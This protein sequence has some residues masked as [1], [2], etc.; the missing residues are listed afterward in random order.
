VDKRN[1][2]ESEWLEELRRTECPAEYKAF[3]ECTIASA[4]GVAAHFR[5]RVLMASRPRRPGPHDLQ[6]QSV[7]EDVPALHEGEVRAPAL[8][9]KVSPPGLTRAMARNKPENFESF[10]K[11]R[12]A[13]EYEERQRRKA[14]ILAQAKEQQQ[15]Q[16]AK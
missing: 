3:G 8:A 12:L 9:R 15:Q 14:E 1:R 2:L 13:Q 10:K 5:P 4:C 7:L 6:V 11:E 16:A